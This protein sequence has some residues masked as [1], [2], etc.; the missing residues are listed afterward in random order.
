M[1]HGEEPGPETHQD[2]AVLTYLEGLLMHPV[3]SGPGATATRR[4]EAGSSNGE[5]GNQGA[6][7]IQLPN[8]GSSPPEKGSPPG[9]AS[10]HLKKARLLRSGTWSETD[11]QKKGPT[12]VHVNGQCK[13]HHELSLDNSAQGE[14]TLLASLLQSFSSRLQTVAMTQNISQSYKQLDGESS[15]R[16]TTDKDTIQG[17]CTASSH[18]KGL[19]RKNKQQSRNTVPYSRRSSQD[20]C[21]ESPRSSQSLGPDR[22]SCAERLKAVASLVKSRSSPAPSPKPSV[23]CSQLALLLSSEAHLQQYSQEQ[24]LKAQLCGRSASERLAAI[25]TQQTKDNRPPSMGESVFDPG[26]LSPFTTLNRILPSPTLNSSQRSPTLGLGQSALTSSPRP[27]S[28]TPKEKRPFDRHS[29]RPP[30]N[31]SSLL[32]LL[33]NNHNSQ[34]HLTK[35]GHLE[36]DF[37]PPSQA[38]HQSDSEYSNPENSLTK[39]SSDAESCY[40][41]CSPIDLSVRSRI[42]SQK[43]EHP[44]S[45]SSLD[46]LTETLI[47]KW[48]SETIGSKVPEAQELEI[49]PDMT[50]HHKVTLMQLLL[51]HRNNEMVNK[52]APQSDLQEDAVSR[53]VTVSPVKR[54]GTLEESRTH[55]SFDQLMGRSLSTSSVSG[56][57]SKTPS[58]FSYS[59]PLVQSSP[60]DLCKTRQHTSEK[61]VEPA[62]TASKLLHN[63]AQCGLQSVS[64]SPPLQASRPQSK[65]QSP[66][67]ELERSRILLDRFAVPLKRNQTPLFEPSPA[68]FSPFSG[69]KPSPPAST[70]IENLLERRTVLQLLLGTASHKENSPDRR[71]TEVAMGVH[72][73][74]PGAFFHCDSSNGTSLNVMVKTEPRDETLLSDS[75]DGAGC[76]WRLDCESH[77]PTV[78]AHSNVKEESKYGLL[79]QLLKQKTTTYQS[80]PCTEQIVSTVKEERQDYQVHLPKKR[81]LCLELAEHLSKELCQRPLDTVSGCLVSGTPEAHNSRRLPSPKEEDSF[82]KSPVSKAPTRDSQNFNVLKQLLLSDN[83]LKEVSKPQGIPSPFLPQANCKANGNFSQPSYN[84]KLVNSPWFPQTPNSGPGRFN[85]L[86]SSPGNNIQGSSWEKASSPRP[87]PKSVKKETES[88]PRWTLPGEDKCESSTDSPPLMRSNPILYYMLQRRNS[89]LRK[90]EEDHAQRTHL[91]VTVKVEP[92][93]AD[94]Y[95]DPKLG[96]ISSVQIQRQSNGGEHL[97][98]LLEK[99]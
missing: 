60:L 15:R 40:S 3:A 64:P 56:H 45:A 39:D 23:A 11:N 62:F 51:D 2:S 53:N 12:A 38:S 78:E 57:T 7:G 28:H 8:P 50:S 94:R 24:T 49:S 93:A 37:T 98:G 90:E 16:S 41:S 29:S 66:E 80:S 5:A 79:S 26:M 10:L 95:H 30:Q 68:T 84:H 70:Q 1:T 25:A 83:C 74:P 77:N 86:S 22:V 73:K 47:S 89:Q 13:E 71:S 82:I 92:C 33:L 6:R 87:S 48:K 27:S 14:S 59:A 99:P 4:P 36:D 9:A 96:T 21:S 43:S 20:R 65:R 31:C 19:I 75:S 52:I 55:N 32:L 46:K 72:E 17:Y 58:P 61:M 34:K 44:S 42:S 88:S 63:L 67:P 85:P 54:I 18:L 35:N 76:H 69:Q 91:G 97:S 81:K